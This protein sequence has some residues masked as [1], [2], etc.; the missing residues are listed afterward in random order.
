MNI[1]EDEGLEQRLEE[2]SDQVGIL[3]LD[4]LLAGLRKARMQTVIF[5]EFA[6]AKAESQDPQPPF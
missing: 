5:R 6:E 2:L 3:V 1:Y 4:L